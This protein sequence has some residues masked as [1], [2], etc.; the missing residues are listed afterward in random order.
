VWYVVEVQVIT[1][2]CSQNPLVTIPITILRNQVDFR[3]VIPAVEIVFAIP[4]DWQ[5]TKAPMTELYAPP[6]AVLYQPN[7]SAPSAPL[8]DVNSLYALIQTLQQSNEWTE[9]AVLKNWIKTGCIDGL[10]PQS[11]G[12]VFKCIKGEYSYTAFPDIIGEAMFG[13]LN[14]KHISG[15]AMAVPEAKRAAVCYNFARYCIDKPNAAIEFKCLGM[16]P[17]AMSLLLISYV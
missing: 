14:C 9:A 13:R 6:I 8:L 5:A 1:P 10:T 11:I 16:P 7:P 4:V 12:S 3:G 2:R 17:Y 15:A